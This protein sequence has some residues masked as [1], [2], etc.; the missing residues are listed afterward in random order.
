MAR[1]MEIKSIQSKMKQKEIAKELGFSSSILHR[2]RYEKEISSPYGSDDPKRSPKTSNDL[3]R[4][5]MISEDAFQYNKLFSKKVR[6]TNNS[7]GGD[8]IDVSP[9]HGRD[10]FKQAFVLQKMAEFKENLKKI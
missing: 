5:Q 4:P 8:P 9:S 10:L 7:K 6:T 3:K 1:F 2:Y